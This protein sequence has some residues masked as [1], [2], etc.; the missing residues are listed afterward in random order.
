MVVN[1]PE[2]FHGVES[3]NWS[4]IVLPLFSFFVF[5]EP[6]GPAEYNDDSLLI[7]MSHTDFAVDVCGR[8]RQWVRLVFFAR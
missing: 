2:V 8:V 1:C 5:E 3:S 6:E 7:N 4:A